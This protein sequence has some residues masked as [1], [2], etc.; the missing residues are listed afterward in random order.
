MGLEEGVD[1]TVGLPVART[2]VGHGTAFDIAG[3]RGEDERSTTEAMRQAVV[4]AP[5]R[6]AAATRA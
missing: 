3:S 2:S 4:M 1:I 6:A 5:G